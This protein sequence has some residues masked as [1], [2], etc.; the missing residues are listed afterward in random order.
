VGTAC[1]GPCSDGRRGAGGGRACPR[2]GGLYELRRTSNGNVLILDVD[3]RLL[4]RT[5]Q[6]AAMQKSGCGTPWASVP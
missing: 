6:T 2:E 4:A 1:P 5:T 3:E